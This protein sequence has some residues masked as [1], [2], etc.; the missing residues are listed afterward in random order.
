MLSNVIEIEKQKFF[1][2]VNLL[3]GFQ[4]DSTAIALMNSQTELKIHYPCPFEFIHKFFMLV[5]VVIEPLAQFYGI[6][7]ALK[8]RNSLPVHLQAVATPSN[9]H[10]GLDEKRH[11]LKRPLQHSKTKSEYDNDAGLFFQSSR[12][13]V[14]MSLI[15]CLIV[16][17][18]IV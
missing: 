12:K 14:Q 11:L 13:V 8:I 3:N 9:S 7:D 16:S 5:T 1:V 4:E 10:Q 17:V 6:W 15:F 2:P 18:I